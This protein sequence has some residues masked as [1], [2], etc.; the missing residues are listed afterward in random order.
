VTFDESLAVL[1]TLTDPDLQ[2][3]AWTFRGRPSDLGYALYH[4]AEEEQRV[5]VATPRASTESARIL[6]LAQSAF[7]D[8][9]GLLAGL[10]ETLLDR[11]PA[12]GEWS[13][14]ET[15]V[16][17][18]GTE[19]SYRAAT[20]YGVARTAAEPVLMPAERRPAPDPADTA[21]GPQDIIARF[22]ARRAETDAALAAVAD[23]DLARP[24][25][26]SGVEVD[27]RH[28]LHRFASHIA[29]HAYQC[30]KAIRA[31][32]AYGGDA[33]T[34]CRRIGALRGLHERRS[35]AKTLRAL[36]TALAE[37]ARIARA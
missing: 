19:R 8:L 27:V 37:K 28:R 9:R 25:V 34:I 30:E 4:A 1:A 36:D 20:E 14:R 2:R 35:E 3:E 11:P 33:R 12:A 16:H 15:L 13:V 6:G 31:L 21:G 23:A 7:G 22:A 17:A 24:V 26:W 29:E 32:D 18:I 10:D 5:V